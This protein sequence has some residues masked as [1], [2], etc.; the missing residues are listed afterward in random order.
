[1]IGN[2]STVMTGKLKLVGTII[3]AALDV[4]LWH[5]AWLGVAKLL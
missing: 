3:P 2:V 4:Q 1:L 5:L